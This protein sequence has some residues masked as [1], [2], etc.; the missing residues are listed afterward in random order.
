MSNFSQSAYLHGFRLIQELSELALEKLADHFKDDWKRAFECSVDEL[1]E[2]GLPLQTATIVANKKSQIDLTHELTKLSLNNISIISY[3]DEDYPELLQEI[4]HK[5]LLLYYIG[6]KII[7]DELC[8]AVV[9]TRKMSGYGKVLTEYFGEPLTKQK[10]TI[11][12]GLAF[13]VD[14]V[15][16]QTALANNGRTI[17]VVGSGLLDNDIYPKAHLNLAKQII[18]TGGLLISEYPPG[19]PALKQN[20][21]ARNRIIAGLC[22]GTIVIECP[23]RSGA[24]VTAKYALEQNRNVY[25][26]PHPLFNDNATGPH[27]LL[28]KGA[29]LITE[30]QDILDDLHISIA[31]TK[32]D[33]QNF[34]ETEKL[35]IKAL[36][37][38]GQTID[39]LISATGL[40]AKTVSASLITL[41]MRG[42]LKNL[43]N[44]GYSLIK[45]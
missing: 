3:L 5:P 18:N 24:L 16:H 11:V 9:G 32:K 33:L 35:L 4:S 20:F 7:S 29:T 28:R 45:K 12:S 26:P 39:A 43:G 6:G 30:A 10:I 13:G 41:E 25:A 2:A 27:M 31:L 21:I 42:V 15:A 38:Q 40:D 44:Q 34:S 8:V 19:T 36:A 37:D 1:I 23:L 22:V 14:A 17:A